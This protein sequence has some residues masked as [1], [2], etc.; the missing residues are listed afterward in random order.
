MFSEKKNFVG[1]DSSNL[2]AF[3][4]H[5]TRKKGASI[6][7][8]GI[9]KKAVEFIASH[10]NIQTIDQDF[11]IHL[12]ENSDL[13][14]PTPGYLSPRQIQ[15]LIEVLPLKLKAFG[16]LLYGCGLNTRECVQLKIQDMEMTS[17][18]LSIR[19]YTKAYRHFQIPTECQIILEDYIR[20]MIQTYRNDGSYFATSSPANLNSS[21][22]F[23]SKV[24]KALNTQGQLN[25]QPISTSYLI[26]EFNKVIYQLFGIQTDSALKLLQNSFIHSLLKEKCTT[27]TIYQVVH[28][29]SKFYVDSLSVLEYQKE[30][31][32]LKSPLKS[33]YS[34]SQ[35]E[36][37]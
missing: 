37:E 26:S 27:D 20:R 24:K 4:Q 21:W 22:L 9:A 25:A 5:I 8:A 10:F 17:N 28:E 12:Q 31:P 36:P 14:S 18:S 6:H 30:K 7:E 11:H 23:P 32:I 3:L 29:E 35:V 1:F 13:N 15:K 16:I 2:N 33:L 19:S 34:T